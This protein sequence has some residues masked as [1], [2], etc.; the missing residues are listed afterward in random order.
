MHSQNHLSKNKGQN[1]FWDRPLFHL[2]LETLYAVM[3]VGGILFSPIF[4]KLSIL[5]YV[6]SLSVTYEWQAM[7]SPRSL[8]EVQNLRPDQDILDKNLYFKKIPR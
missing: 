1:K 3:K 7:A 5:E 2:H 6:R 8:L 4:V